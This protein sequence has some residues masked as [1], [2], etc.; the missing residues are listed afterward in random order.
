M[1]KEEIEL[2]KD[3]IGEEAFEDMKRKGISIYFKK[4]YSFSFSNS[5]WITGL[6][7]LTISGKKYSFM[8]RGNQ[9]VSLVLIENTWNAANF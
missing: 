6:T 4:E 9:P 5:K 3:L 1:K 2:E 8:F 7:Y